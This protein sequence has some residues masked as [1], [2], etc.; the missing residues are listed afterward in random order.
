MI[1]KFKTSRYRGLGVVEAAIIFPVLILVVFGLIEYGWLFLKMHQVSNITR[2]AAR[3]AI[4]PSTTVPSQVTTE[5]NILM[6]EAN[7]TG[8]NTPVITNL[9]P[10]IGQP[11]TVT[12]TVPIENIAVLNIPLLPLPASIGSTVTMAKEGP[13]P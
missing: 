4:L 13:G 6:A 2:H 10:G 8:Y 9:T 7:I 3:I 5:V 1:K 12:I 11:V